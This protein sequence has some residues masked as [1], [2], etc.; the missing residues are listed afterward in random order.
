MA[1]TVVRSP[2]KPRESI[3]VSENSATG[4]MTRMLAVG[5]DRLAGEAESRC[6]GEIDHQ[7]SLNGA[8]EDDDNEYVV[9]PNAIEVCPLD[10]MSSSGHGALM[11]FRS[12]TR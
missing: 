5:V 10:D 11:R 9:R 2:G 3:H 12:F 7:P 1:P 6:G 8:G 4:R